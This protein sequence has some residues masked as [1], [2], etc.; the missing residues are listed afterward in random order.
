MGNE[1][2]SRQ[3]KRFR[4]RIPEIQFP[5]P[6]VDVA[7]RVPQNGDPNSDGGKTSGRG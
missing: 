3:R 7:E 5:K 6:A 4:A 2:K 1:G